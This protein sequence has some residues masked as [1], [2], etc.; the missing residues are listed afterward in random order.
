MATLLRNFD[1]KMYA[2]LLNNKFKFCAKYNKLVL[3]LPPET[4]EIMAEKNFAYFTRFEAGV[5]EHPL[6][7]KCLLATGHLRKDFYFGCIRVF[8]MQLENVPEST[9]LLRFAEKFPNLNLVFDFKNGDIG[10][11]DPRHEGSSTACASF[12]PTG[13]IYISAFN[14]DWSV[15]GIIVHALASLTLN[16]VYRDARKPYPRDDSEREKEFKE[17]IAECRENYKNKVNFVVGDFYRVFETFRGDKVLAEL[18]FCVPHIL[19]GYSEGELIETKVKFAKI[20]DYYSK[21][22]TADIELAFR[23]EKFKRI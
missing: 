7:A 19:A 21:Y 18:V 10:F 11:M 22:V 9:Q 1:V 3:A 16:M 5:G 2:L 6:M 13:L 23:S 15:C 17:A 20:F 12:N 4:R 14:M 8:L